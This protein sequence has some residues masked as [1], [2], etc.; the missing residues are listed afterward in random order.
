MTITF[1]NSFKNVY[2]VTSSLFLHESHIKSL[3]ISFYIN[4]S[5]DSSKF[6]VCFTSNDKL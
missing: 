5:K 4:F 3:I 2:F 1:G 6:S